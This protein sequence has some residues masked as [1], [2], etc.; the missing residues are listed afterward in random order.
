M[1][2]L[3]PPLVVLDLIDRPLAVPST[4]VGLAAAVVLVVGAVTVARVLL[5][6][7]PRLLLQLADVEVLA[8]GAD[9]FD[10]VPE[11]MVFACPAGVCGAL[12]ESVRLAIM[13]GP[14]SLYRFDLLDQPKSSQ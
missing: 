12:E 6:H 3:L 1:E 10:D 13:I 14:R 2:S 5:I 4:P 8:G 9:D 7:D 11:T